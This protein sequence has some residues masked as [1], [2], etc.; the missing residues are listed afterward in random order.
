MLVIDGQQRL[1]TL[2]YFYSEN[3]NDKTIFSLSNVEPQFEGK[4]YSKLSEEQ[5]RR[6]DDSIIHATIIKQDRPDDGDSS[7]YHIFERLNTGGK[8][9]SPQEIRACIYHGKFNDIITTLNNNTKWRKLFGGTSLRM[10]DQEM[11]L[12][13]FSLFYSRS[14]YKKGIAKFLNNFMKSNKNLEEIPEEKLIELF[15]ST[16]DTIYNQLGS[17]AFKLNIKFIAALFDAIMIGIG[18]G[19]EKNNLVSPKILITRYNSLL[20]NS[21]FKEAIST[22]TSDPEKVASRIKLAIKVFTI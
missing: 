8:N 14:S 11:I 18:V 15:N 20:S 7:I 1:K 9:L 6:L 13:F 4:T 5:R 12:R 3:F 21:E 17:N 16:I 2:K 22:H 19:L 10:R